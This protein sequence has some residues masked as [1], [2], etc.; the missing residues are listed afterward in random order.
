MRSARFLCGVGAVAIVIAAHIVSARATN[1]PSQPAAS[2]Q[3]GP[4]DIGGVVSSSKG[5]K[6]ASG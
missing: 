3:V 4:N 2:V 1:L 5:P 6:P